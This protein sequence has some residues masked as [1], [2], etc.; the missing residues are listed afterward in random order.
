MS[1]ALALAGPA[2]RSTV[3]ARCSHAC[4]L[5]LLAA[6]PELSLAVPWS[7]TRAAGAGLPSGAVAWMLAL[8]LA[9][10]PGALAVAWWAARAAGVAL[11]SGEVA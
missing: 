11:S 1:G 9:A 4:E 10:L 5:L 3:S 2:G 8:L 6:L 7:S